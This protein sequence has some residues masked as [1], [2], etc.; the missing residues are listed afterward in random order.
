MIG[1]VTYASRCIINEILMLVRKSRFKPSIDSLN[2]LVNIN[3]DDSSET[4]LMD[5][6]SSDEDLTQDYE[7]KEQAFIVREIVK[8]LPD[9]QRLMIEMYFGLNG[10]RRHNQREIGDCFNMSQSYISR[11]LIKILDEIE[12][13]VSKTN[14]NDLYHQ[15]S[16][17]NSIK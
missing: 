15:K 5:F 10:Q 7:E 1:L 11:L 16:F 8:R 17:P 3:S 4:A 13:K 9:K 12:K 6:L 2:R 14:V